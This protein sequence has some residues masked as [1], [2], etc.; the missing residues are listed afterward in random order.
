M[1]QAPQPQPQAA[2]SNPAG[3]QAAQI[4]QA[5]GV[6]IVPDANASKSKADKYGLGQ[7]G[8][9]QLNTS[10]LFD[11]A[12]MTADDAMQKFLQWGQDSSKVGTVAAIQQAL[13]LSGNYYTSSY[14]FVPGVVRP[15]DQT[16]FAKFLIQNAQMQGDSGAGVQK[17]IATVLQDN[18]QRGV[19]F[20]ANAAAP[21][22]TPVYQ[23]PAVADLEHAAVSAAE[24]VLGRKASPVE[25]TAFAAYYRHMTANYYD[26]MTG[27]KAQAKAQAKA[28]K[29]AGLPPAPNDVNAQG[30]PLSAVDQSTPDT[31]ILPAAPGTAAER[32]NLDAGLQ[33][34]ATVPDTTDPNAFLQHI[35]DIAGV[36]QG[37][38]A[39]ASA[40]P[41]PLMVNSPP[42]ASVA[43]EDYMR[44]NNP[45][46]AGASDMSNTF[47]QFL[48]IIS[49]KLV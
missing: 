28:A 39:Q 4:A 31:G 26:D 29:A 20:G 25:Q 41:D 18:A 8:Q 9:A 37:Q 47:N 38:A 15:Q 46:E 35:S 36:A 21:A 43:A 34:P 23:M 32:Y 49:G 13:Y 27:S 17:P 44:Q 16:A 7:W 12:Q 11:T 1:A 3:G 45:G 40:T 33:Q 19:A 30:I 22:Q 5:L 2:V 14:Q 6:G 10:G 48:K 24:N 42:S